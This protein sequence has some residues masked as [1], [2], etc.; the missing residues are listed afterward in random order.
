MKSCMVG[1]LQMIFLG[2]EFHQNR[3]I[4]FGAVGGQNL[5]IP[6]DLAIGLYNSLYYRTSR[7]IDVKRAADVCR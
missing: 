1:G 6:I 4:G 5:P 7:D 3:L 2:F